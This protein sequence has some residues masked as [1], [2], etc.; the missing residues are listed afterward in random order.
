MVLSPR[1]KAIAAMVEEGSRLADIGTDHG[2]LPIWL[3]EEGRIPSAIAMDVREGPLLRAKA[4]VTEHG[5]LDRVTVRLSDGFSAL[6]LGEADG[7]VIAGMG[8]P[9]TIRILERGQKIA[10]SLR[11]LVLSPQSEVPAVRHYLLEK[12]YVIFT[13]DM[14]L[15]EGKYYT[16]IKAVHEK[17]EDP[18]IREVPWS[19]VEESYGRHLLRSGKSVV[20]EFLLKEKNTKMA[21]KKTLL[22]AET[23]RARIR[24]TQV[25]EELK[26]LDMAISLTET[27]KGLEKRS[28]ESWEKDET[29]KEKVV[30]LTT[31]DNRKRTA[32]GC[33]KESVEGV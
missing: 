24:L 10:K 11:Y 31:A 6:S 15:D 12:G 14:V 19:F 23:D 4:H 20:R 7:A 32:N 9:L 25:E 2:Y 17:R 22:L 29:K 18:C 30:F 16:V 33:T 8:G 3:L 27:K 1:L 26:L 28:A 13:E 21:V 5:L